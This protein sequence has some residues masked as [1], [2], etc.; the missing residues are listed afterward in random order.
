MLRDLVVALF[1]EALRIGNG[2]VDRLPCDFA[3]VGVD[4]E[5]M[6]FGSVEVEFRAV[7]NGTGLR[8]FAQM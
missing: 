3:P 4:L 6:G 1:R 7:V 5:E 2:V 8:F